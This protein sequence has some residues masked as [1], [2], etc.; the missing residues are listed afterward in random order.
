M[1]R[2]GRRAVIDAYKERK[3]EAGIYAVRCLPS[4]QCWVGRT[5]DV[6]KIQN[7]LRS[8]LRQGGHPRPALNEAWRKHGA[9]AFAIEIVE[10]IEP[11]ES[12][13]LR[14]AVLKERLAHWAAALGA[15]A[16]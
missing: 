1:D 8:T 3:V 15:T 9:E 5:A 12:D 13:Y 4:G 10:A 6:S 7:R 14:E 16:I 11:P 2:A